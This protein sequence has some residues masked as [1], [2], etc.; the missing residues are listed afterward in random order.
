MLSLLHVH[1][2]TNIHWP[3]LAGLVASMVHVWA[4]PDHLAAVVPL[5]FERVKGQWRIGAAWGLGHV[6]GMLIIG[7]L[8]YFFKDLIPVERLS[9]YSEILVA[10]IL[11]FIGIRAIFRAQNAPR[12]HEHP[13]VHQDEK[14]SYVHIHQHTHNSKNHSHKKREQ[15][16]AKTALGIGIVHGFAGISHFLIMLPVLGY[17]SDMDSAQYLFG[18]A[19]GTVVAMALFAWLLGRLR[20]IPSHEHRPRFLRI[21]QWSG[22]IMAIAVGIVW[23]L[24]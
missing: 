11:I 6:G 22:G 14:G 7:L 20:A 10:L 8:F 1:E 5:V 13:H 23:L 12:V 21:L 17:K 4:G 24:I 9:S 3:L 2:T 16:G 15:Q 18:F 19:A